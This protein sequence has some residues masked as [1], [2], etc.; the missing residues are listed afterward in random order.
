[1]VIVALKDGIYELDLETEKLTFICMPENPPIEGNK[2]NDGKCDSKGRL[3][4]G[5]MDINGNNG[6]GGF[7]VVNGNANAFA[8]KILSAPLGKNVSIERGRS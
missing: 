7:Y 3:W 1:M 4:V 6:K 2:Y 8:A 5:T